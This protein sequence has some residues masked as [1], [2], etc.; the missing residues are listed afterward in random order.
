MRKRDGLAC[1]RSRLYQPVADRAGPGPRSAEAGLSASEPAQP[2]FGAAHP[3]ELL[4]DGSLDDRRAPPK[5]Q[6]PLAVFN[7]R[8]VLVVTEA[9]HRA[10]RF[11]PSALDP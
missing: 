11:H 4:C 8:V 7:G 9:S 1:D 3:V 5:R 10:G 6:R 2:L